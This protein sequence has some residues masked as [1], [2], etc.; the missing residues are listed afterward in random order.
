MLK[1]L[2]AHRLKT[3]GPNPWLCRFSPPWA[4]T[5]SSS[6]TGPASPG[7]SS[8]FPPS[9]CSPRPSLLWRLGDLPSRVRGP[10][11]CLSVLPLGR[12]QLSAR[13]LKTEDVPRVRTCLNPSPS[14]TCSPTRKG[15]VQL[16]VY[17]NDK[18][19]V[20]Q[21]LLREKLKFSEQVWPSCGV[22]RPKGPC[23]KVPCRR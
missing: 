6:H 8:G 7:S 20:T 23:Y 13:L 4:L 11:P 1:I 17:L 15:L 18:T 3:C 14:N 21:A 9:A 19:A 12:P 16:T 2:A 22:S 5:S 10:H